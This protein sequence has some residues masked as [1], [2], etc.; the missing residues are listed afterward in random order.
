MI[1]SICPINVCT[2]FKINRYKID[3]FRKYA[4]IVFYL[5]SRDTQIMRRTSWGLDIGISIRNIM[6]P[7]RSIYDL[8]FQ[9]YGSN[10]SYHVFWWPWPWPFWPMFYLSHALG[11]MHW[12]LHAK[13]HMNPSSI[14]G[15]YGRWYGRGHTHKLTNTHTH[16]EGHSNCLANAFDARLTKKTT[17]ITQYT[18]WID[19]NKSINV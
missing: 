9:S 13:F 5:T 15:W 11:I 18:K 3:E 16:T 2:D 1:H 19:N 14:N 17:C 10:S 4:K 6:K 7:T 12:N 8:R